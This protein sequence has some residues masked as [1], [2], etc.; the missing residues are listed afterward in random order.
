MVRWPDIQKHSEPGGVNDSTS[1]GDFSIL[2]SSAWLQPACS[3]PAQRGLRGHGAV[4]PE[5]R[6]G[7]G[8]AV[9]IGSKVRNEGDEQRQGQLWEPTAA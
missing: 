2:G 8:A 4:R 3:A 5:H 6:G 7:D 9:S 1:Y